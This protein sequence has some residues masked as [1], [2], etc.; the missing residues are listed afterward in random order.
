MK[1]KGGSGGALVYR[2]R[3]FLLLVLGLFER[4]KRKRV[5]RI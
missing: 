2:G 4:R 3:Y 5:R 1:E